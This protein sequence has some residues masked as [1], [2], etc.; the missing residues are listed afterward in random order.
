MIEKIKIKLAK[1]K[2]VFPLVTFLFLLIMPAST[3]YKLKDFG[4]G[5]GGVGN[6]TTGSVSMNAISGEQGGGQESLGGFKMGP[7]LVFNQQANV[8]LVP[9]FNNPSNYY[10]KLQ[11]ILNTSSNPTDTN[12]AIAISSDNFVTTNYI[13]SD[14][15]VGTTLALADYQTYATWGGASGFYVIGLTANTTYKVKV[16]AMQGK[17]TET[18]YSPIVSAVT[19]NSTL[20]FGITTDNQSNPPFAVDFSVMATG[21]VN[22]ASNKIW[23]SLSTNGQS[24]GKIYVTGVNA[25]LVSSSA[26]YA[27]SSVTG[28]LNSLGEGFGAQGVSATQTSGGP[29]AITTGIYS[30]AGNT[31]G[32]V[33]TNVREIFN[34]SGPITGG[35]GSFQLKSKPATTARPAADYTE[36]LK[37]IAS[38]NF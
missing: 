2:K 15:T 1:I 17:F 30:Q 35:S 19:V 29:L 23:A 28:D 32:I 9:A 34:S 20:S 13:K 10:N 5:S 16:K 8:P 25:G 12:Y 24:G 38:G 14:D 22:T 6:A 36:T 21:S 27:I 37:V 26:G 18:G 7:G 3:N 11:I 33:D 31:V 4:F